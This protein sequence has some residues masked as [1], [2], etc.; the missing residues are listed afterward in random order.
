MFGPKFALFQEPVFMNLV[1]L[2]LSRE[3]PQKE[4]S[5]IK[6]LPKPVQIE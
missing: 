3:S 4:A 6:G 1:C 2:V 5:F